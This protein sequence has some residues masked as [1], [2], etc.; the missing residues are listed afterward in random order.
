MKYKGIIFDF[1]GV[2]FFDSH[3]H[4]LAWNNFSEKY[5]GRKFTDDEIKNH[6]HGRQNSQILSYVLE[7]EI[8]GDELKIYTEE[9]ESMYRNMCLNDPG[10]F[11]L[12][13]GAESLLN[14]LKENNIPRTI[15]TASEINNLTFFFEHLN[16]ATWFELEKC[17]WDSGLIRGKPYPDK[18]II[19]AHIIGLHPKDSIVVEDSISGMKSAIGAGVGWVYGLGKKDSSEMMSV[20]GLSGIITDLTEFDRNLFVV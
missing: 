14:F 8:D 11:V 20:E 1:N 3:L 9:K 15:A 10:N 7:K 13:T 17:V 2:L 12:S 5:R 18:F 19:A 16:L 6:L 4:E